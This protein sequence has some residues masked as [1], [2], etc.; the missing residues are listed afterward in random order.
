MMMIWLGTAAC[1]F[2]FMD[3]TACATTA[4]TGRR[5]FHHVLGVFLGNGNARHYAVGIGQGARGLYQIRR[6]DVVI[7]IAVTAA[8]AAF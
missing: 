4:T 7:M 6:R 2:P 1:G 8:A 5:Q 3:A